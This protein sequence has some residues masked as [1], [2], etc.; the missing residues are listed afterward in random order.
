VNSTGGFTDPLFSLLIP[1]VVH[2]TCMEYLSFGFLTAFH[3]ADWICRILAFFSS[4]FPHN[5]VPQI[6][7]LCILIRTISVTV[8]NESFLLWN[9]HTSMSIFFIK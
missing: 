2:L 8:A 7:F 9:S 1:Y 4:I 5:L 3:L 6:D